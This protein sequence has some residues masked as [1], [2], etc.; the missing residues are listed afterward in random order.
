MWL[1][2]LQEVNYLELGFELFN[3]LL[4]MTESINTQKAQPSYNMNDY[5]TIGL[6]ALIG[7]CFS[8]LLVPSSF[9][10]RRNSK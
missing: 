4:N 7:L 2:F 6:Y 8:L 1:V 5:K 9:A 10:C 3:F